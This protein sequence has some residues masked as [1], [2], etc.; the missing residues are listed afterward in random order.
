MGRGRAAADL[1]A[2]RRGT[3][4]KPV[5]RPVMPLSPQQRLLLLDTWQRSGLPA[6]DFA[7]LVGVSKHTLYAW[8]KRFEELGPAG[9]WISPGGSSRGASCRS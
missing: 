3:L 9:W 4:A 1:K 8:K 2:R 7:A 5:E 6:R